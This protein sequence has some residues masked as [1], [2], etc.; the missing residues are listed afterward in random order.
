MPGRLV[1]LKVGTA[2]SGTLTSKTDVQASLPNPCQTQTFHLNAPLVGGLRSRESS[3]A[4]RSES[5]D[6]VVVGSV[7]SAP[8]AAEPTS[9]ALRTP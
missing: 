5:N 8:R 4:S 6:G 2:A 3:R 7:G 1:H 9:S